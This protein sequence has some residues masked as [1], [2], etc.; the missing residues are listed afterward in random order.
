M[1]FYF[2]SVHSTNIRGMSRDAKLFGK[3]LATV[4]C[5]LKVRWQLTT[6][7]SRPATTLSTRDIEQET[8]ISETNSLLLLKRKTK[9]NV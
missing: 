2:I 6:T 8:E 7:T 5:N 1:N 3:T 4:S 9:N